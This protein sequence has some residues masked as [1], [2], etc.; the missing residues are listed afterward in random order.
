MWVPPPG[1]VDTAEILRL[2][3]RPSGDR[4]GEEASTRLN[5]GWFVW[6]Y[7]SLTSKVRREWRG[8]TRDIASPKCEVIWLN[9][10]AVSTAS[11]P[12]VPTVLRRSNLEKKSVTILGL[13]IGFPIAFAAAEAFPLNSPRRNASAAATSR[14]GCHGILSVGSGY[15]CSHGCSSGRLSSHKLQPRARP[16]LL[17]R[18]LPLSTI[19][20]IYTRC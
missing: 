11:E 14:Q 16:A 7:S 12:T 17:T 6:M 10:P 13:L 18:R 2:A 15:H 1:V 8:G 20:D 19:T 4:T 5:C 9:A 3:C